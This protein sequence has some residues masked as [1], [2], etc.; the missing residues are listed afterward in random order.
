MIED[1]TPTFSN[2]KNEKNYYAI[3]AACS[4]YQDPDKNLPKKPLQPISEEKLTRIYKSLLK[5]KNWKEGNIIL[6][7]N[8]NATKSKIL[9]AFNETVNRIDAN[10]VFIFS[11]CGH[12]SQI[13]DEDGDE[14]ID[15]QTDYYDEIICPYDFNIENDSYINPI[16]DDE[17]NDLFNMIQ[18]DGMFILIESC[19]SG[20]LVDNSSITNF[21]TYDIGL[22][23][24]LSRTMQINGDIITSSDR[25]ILTS[26]PGDYRGYVIPSIGFPLTTGLSYA[27]SSKRNDA[28]NDGFIS[29]EESYISTVL[30]YRMASN[31][32][33]I[34]PYILI[35][36]MFKMGLYRTVRIPFFENYP[37]LNDLIIRRGN[38]P[39]KF[40]IIFASIQLF[41]LFNFMILFRIVNIPKIY[42]NYDGELNLIEF[43]YI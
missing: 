23:E 28:N 21:T 22:K 43:N 20:S 8:E 3:I 7:I 40:P 16:T 24:D 9:S 41:Y 13:L 11:W 19:Y 17:L 25:I 33:F 34:P 42:D 18:C 30:F 39:Q 31:S 29:V 6:L 36:I 26:T 35:I 15:N 14:L 1:S 32:F 12:G 38:L 37:I 10:D 2:T 4:E 27:L 5:S